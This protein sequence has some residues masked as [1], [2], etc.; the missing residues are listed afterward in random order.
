MSTVR[1]WGGHSLIL[2]A[3]SQNCI[4]TVRVALLR[5]ELCTLCTGVRVRYSTGAGRLREKILRLQSVMVRYAT[6]DGS[7]FRTAVIEG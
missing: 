6:N 1:Y 4:T 3:T 7:E 2:K 5:Y